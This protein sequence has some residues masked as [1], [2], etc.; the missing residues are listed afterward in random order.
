M[1]VEYVNPDGMHAPVD[2]MYAHVAIAT[3]TT[4]IRICEQVAVDADGGNVSPGDMA[5]QIQTC[6]EMVTT[7]LDAAGA[8]WRD[9]VHI[10]TYTTDID[11]YMEAEEAVVRPFFGDTPPPS[12]VVQVVRLIDP[13]WLVAVQVDAVR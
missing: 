6:Y 2:N 4:L 12:T 5:G 9:V 13:A 7:A 3:G 10:A 11:A 8:T 1:T